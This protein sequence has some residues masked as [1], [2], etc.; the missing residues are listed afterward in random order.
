MNFDRQ[1]TDFLTNVRKDIQGQFREQDLNASG[2]AM[3][4]LKVVANQYIK[5]QIVGR[6]Y[7]KYLEKGWKGRP[8]SVG[9]NF[10]DNIIQ[11]MSFRG[12]Q[13]KRDGKIIPSTETN[14]KRSAFG[15]AKGITQFGTS[16]NKGFKG[17]EFQKAIN[18]NM[19]PFLQS[20]GAEFTIEFKEKL[21]IKRK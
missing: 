17:L 6:R 20:I 11:W 5:A 1:F 13:P 2:F 10:V 12:I 19:S 4:S 18:Q 7:T 8:K 16:V 3:N 15:I 9:R 14:I 21:K